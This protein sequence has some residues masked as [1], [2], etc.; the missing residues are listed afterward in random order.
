MKLKEELKSQALWLKFKLK[1]SPVRLV[2]NTDAKFPI[3][4][5]DFSPYLLTYH[6]LR[7][8]PYLEIDIVY[9]VANDDYLENSL[10]HVWIAVND[11]LIDITVDQFNLI[12]D[13]N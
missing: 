11:W 8:H 13:E 1:N 7:L 4:H 5:C 6:L 9:G 12:E 10:N 3:D 2:Y